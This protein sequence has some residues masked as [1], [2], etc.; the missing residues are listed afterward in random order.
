MHFVF[1]V[2]LRISFLFFVYFV[3]IATSAA[4]GMKWGAVGWG[5][6]CWGL[7]LFSVSA[8]VV[9][10]G[11]VKWLFVGKMIAISILLLILSMYYIIVI[12]S[13]FARK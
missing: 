4:I 1:V 10:E 9:S 12:N 5:A 8:P 6:G 3:I 13:L 7:T 11:I 2:V